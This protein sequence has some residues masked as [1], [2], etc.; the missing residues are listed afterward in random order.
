[1][2]KITFWLFLL[3]FLQMSAQTGIVVVG[4]N[5]GSND[6]Y[7]QPAPLQDYW[8]NSRQQ[9]I[10]TASEL[11]SAGLVAGNITK[12]GWNVTSIGT[13]GLEEGYTISMGTTTSSNFAST[14]F[15]NVSNV[16]Y[17]PTDF[18]PSATGQ[19]MF[20]LTTPFVW[21]GTSN[22]IIQ[23]CEGATSGAYTTNVVTTYST[24]TVNRSLYYTSD[25]VSA[26]PTTT[27]TLTMNRPQLVIDGAV[28]S[29][30]PPT[31]LS[32]S[33]ITNSGASLSW[34]E[35]NGA[36][37]WSVEYGVSG[38]TQG[39]GT[40]LS[41]ATNPQA[42]SGLLANTDYQYYV[43]SN[44][45]SGASNWA[46]PYTFRTACSSVT[47]F[48]ENF[49][50]T[51][52]GSLPSCW[53]KI[54]SNGVSTY[55]TVGVS[56]TA[57]SS[58][59]G[60]TMYNSSSPSASYIML[61]CPVVSNLS[62]GT[63]RLVFKGNTSTATEDVIVG[64]MSNPADGSTFTPLQTVDLTTSYAQYIVNFASYTGTDSYIAFRK[65]NTSTYTYTY[66]DDIVW[67]PIPATAPA[68]A[69]GITAT[70]NATCGN[71]PTTIS[72]GAVSGADGYKL[73]IGTTAGG[74]DILNNSNLGN[75]TTYS[76]T[77]NLNTTYHYTLTPFN[78]VGDAVNCASQ[79]FTT[80][81]TGCYCDPLYT[82]GKT[83]GDLISNISISG[84]TL[85]NNT[86]TDAVN[87]AYTYFTGQPNYTGTLQA[88]STYTVSVSVGSF[89]GQNVA[90][91][92]DYNDNY[93][94]EASE[95]VGYTT[96]SIASNGSATFSITLAC[97]PPLGTHRMRVRD[98]WNTTGSSISPCATYGYG[99]TEDYNVTVSA[100][101][102]CP[103]PSNLSATAITPNS[104]ILS[105]NIGCAE[106]SWDVHVALAGSGAPTGTPSHPNATSPLTL[107]SLQPATAY[108]FYVRA[109][110]G[111]NGFSVWTGPFTFS[112][113]AL[114][115]VNDDCTGAIA[116]TAG[117]VFTDNAIIGTNVSA[118]TGQNIPAPGCAGTLAGEVW[119]TATVPASGS[120][121]IET[122][123]NGTILTDT[124]LAVYSGSCGNLVLVQCDD[125]SSADGNF[126]KVAL[127]G[128]TP[129]EVLYVAV[130]E[131]GNDTQDTFKVSAYDASLASNTFDTG[132]F[133][134]Y[135]NP[136]K[137][138]LTV[139]YD[140][141]ID[142]AQ[143]INLLGQVVKDVTINATESTI[144]MSSLP[145]GAYIVKFTSN[146]QVQ[147]IKVIKE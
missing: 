9:Y 131:Y 62:A 31:A 95:R 75:V 7:S 130:W 147:T 105:W 84:T 50:T 67:E 41:S 112:T 100:A 36:T 88:G 25:S 145:T 2:K 125:D 76:F 143:I 108:E 89:G 128:R 53:Q 37:S 92:I 24:L 61:V 96:T 20:T 135:P 38:F 82:T 107:S 119:F 93:I 51:S 19:V 64:T 46:G 106:T 49:D 87:P 39:G 116:L 97:N 103:Q 5:S 109:N 13:S 133:V 44:C 80:V 73:S 129:G 59:N 90:V 34:T 110:C 85:A 18:T 27:G 91:W 21:D 99:E 48:S 144:D 58:P 15:E 86:G 28:A 63:H 69:T 35:P 136:V 124:G 17:G 138:S 40:L 23:I 78:V 74:T 14:T 55:A 11:L 42:V 6:A 120:I 79:S 43:K 142:K 140:K 10:Y 29:C 121:T 57:S 45:T 70:V 54:L 47:S 33:N 126:S 115:P 68:C 72:W 122:G 32:V 12:I 114:P 71:F 8:K 123:N 104:A 139:S 83:S 117:G 26:C 127:T 134:Y 94:F 3:M 141:N 66:L 98:V 30:L 111:T 113:I 101:V 16:V 65:P 4:A 118:T 22:I 60:V 77:G 1:M 81:A 52:L 137:H 146:T 102:A 56:T 132:R